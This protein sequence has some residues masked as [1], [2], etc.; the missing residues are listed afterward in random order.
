MGCSFSGLNAIYSA[1]NGG[2]DVWINENRFRILKQ[3][4]E[5]GFTF[6]YLVKEIVADAAV[7]S[8]GLAAKKFIDPSHL[9]NDGMY[10]LKKVLIQSDEQLALVRQEV[11]VSSLFNHPNLLPLLD[12]AIIT[13]KGAQ[14]GSMNHEAY[15]L[16][17]VHLD[18]TL[19]DDIKSMKAK[20]DFFPTPT[21][22]QIFRQICTGLN[23]M[24]IF[25]PPY[26]HNDVEPGN[27]L[28]T[29]KQGKPP[30]A[31]L[32]DFGSSQPA[33]K[34][35]RSHS[36]AQQLQ[37]WAAEHCSAL[38]R[39]PELWDCSNHA[40]V[41]ERTDVWSLGCTLYAMMYGESPFEYAQ[42]ESEDSLK[43][44]IIGAQ[45]KRP[46]NVGSSYPDQLHQFVVWLLQPQPAIR[47]H[48][49]DILVHVDKLIAKFST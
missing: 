13:V 41:D 36:E 40:D 4:G 43:E 16:F 26:A 17:P 46:T 44:A 19:L 39:A 42:G 45:I 34:Q 21:L 29:H 27:I 38:Y 14:N 20:K 23:H 9:S 15:L 18:G 32:M 47:P 48:V 49:N 8:G 35:I 12:H 28:I 25:D 7:S 30:I 3:L 1:A 11:H 31:I 37:A 5:G 2:G 33:R 24:H 22:L 6:V 10:A